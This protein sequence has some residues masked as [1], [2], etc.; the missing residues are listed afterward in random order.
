[1]N[2]ILSLSGFVLLELLMEGS[3]ILKFVH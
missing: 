1:L 3:A 2:N